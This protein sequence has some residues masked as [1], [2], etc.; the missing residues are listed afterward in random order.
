MV[1]NAWY[2][3]CASV[4]TLVWNVSGRYYTI[5]SYTQTRRNS[6]LNVSLTRMGI[7]KTTQNSH[8]R[9][10]LEKGSVLGVTLLMRRTS[11]LLHQFSR[12]S[13][14]WRQKMKTAT[15]SLSNLGWPSGV[16]SSCKSGLSLIS[17]WSWQWDVSRHPAKFECSISP[18][19]K[20]AHDLILANSLSWH[21]TFLLGF[22][23]S[24]WCKAQSRLSDN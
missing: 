23:D 10:G 9:S 14:W 24:L 13:M 5:P 8:W 21:I 22:C 16:G 6:N 3:G 18:R 12:Y 19:D 2:V 15:I 20:L 4:G 17:S 1:A 7:S 11:S